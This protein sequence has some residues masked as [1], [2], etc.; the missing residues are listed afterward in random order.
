MIKAIDD[1]ILNGLHSNIRKSSYFSILA[2]ES[3]DIT[4]QEELS[5]LPVAGK[6]KA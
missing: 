4:S 6:R 3:Q 2:D 1:W 5:V